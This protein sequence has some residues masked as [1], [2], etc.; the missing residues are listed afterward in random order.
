MFKEGFI[1]PLNR[2]VHFTWS[3]LMLMQPPNH[4]CNLFLAITAALRA[5]RKSLINVYDSFLES[6]LK[7][8]EPVYLQSPHA[9][10]HNPYHIAL[11]L[12]I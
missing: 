11:W 2:L 12:H 4:Y 10:T 7:P 6:P 9:S 8:C 3:A 5:L 1:D